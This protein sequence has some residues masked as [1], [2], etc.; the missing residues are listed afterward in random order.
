MFGLVKK[1]HALAEKWFGVGMAGRLADLE[2]GR[3]GA[4]AVVGGEEWM[5]TV[6]TQRE[7]G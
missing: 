1:V 5:K 4:Y 3:L 7:E 2:G 6:L